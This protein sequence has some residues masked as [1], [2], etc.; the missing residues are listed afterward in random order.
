MMIDCHCH[1]AS[2]AFDPDRKE[3]IARALQADVKKIIVVGEDFSD[4]LRVLE[5]CSEYPGILYPCLG[6]HPDNF[7]DGLPPA[8]SDDVESVAELVRK[9]RSEIV[10][11]G[12]VGLD[13]WQAKTPERQNLQKKCLEYM[14]ALAAELDLPLNVHSRSAGHYVLDLLA[15]C[16]VKRVL[17]HAFDGKASY[18]LHAAE[19]HGWIFSIPPSLLRSEQK[20]KLVQALPLEFMAL[21]SDSPV[22]GPERGCRNEPG[23]IIHTVS[24]MAKLKGTIRDAIIQKTGENARRLFRI[25]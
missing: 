4:D 14:A 8:S 18:A 19:A 5:I 22:L 23:N 20:Q 11:I 21:E 13:Y 6:F 9:H 3:V 25:K 16:G 24:L 15:S 7:S 17:M 1:L 2:S 12:E 10:A